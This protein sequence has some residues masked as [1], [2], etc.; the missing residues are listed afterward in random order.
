[1]NST[2]LKMLRTLP[3]TQ[4]RKWNESVNKMLFAYNATRNDVTGY[5]PHYLMFGREPLLAIDIILGIASQNKYSCAE[6]AEK[7]K[8]QMQEAYQIVQEKVFKRKEAAE[9][10]WA[11]NHL[12]ASAL[13]PG[14]RVLI[15]DTKK[16]VGPRKIQSYWIRR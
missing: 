13:H 8:Q 7:W 1:M 14:D 11:K 9:K 15:K 2:L 16:V 3:E 10:Q 5:S 6:F 4:K 12:I